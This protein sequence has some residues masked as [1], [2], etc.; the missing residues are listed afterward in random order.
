[1]VAG[2]L[3]LERWYNVPVSM[4]G[5]FVLVRTKTGSYCHP[6]RLSRGTET[7]LENVGKVSRDTGTG[8]DSYLVHLGC[9][10][11]PTWV[12]LLTPEELVATEK[13]EAGSYKR[14]IACAMW[15]VYGQER[16]ST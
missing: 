14:C 12:W 5:Q 6:V 7:G 8:V 3:R 9:M 16:P 13:S 15:L 2:S 11:H 4:K 10:E 1:M